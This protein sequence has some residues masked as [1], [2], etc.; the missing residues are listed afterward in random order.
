MPNRRVK[1][2]TLTKLRYTGSGEAYREAIVSR[3]VVDRDDVPEFIRCELTRGGLP[4]VTSIDFR[5]QHDGTLE[6]WARES[7]EVEL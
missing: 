5:C 7:A 6:R 4:T 1:F 3:E 2:I